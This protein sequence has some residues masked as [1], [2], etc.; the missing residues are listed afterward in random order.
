MSG[1]RSAA[2]DAADP[3]RDGA[4]PAAAVRGGAGHGRVPR[5]DPGEERLSAQLA[6]RRSGDGRPA[7]VHH[8]LRMERLRSELADP[9]H[10]AD[11]DRGPRG[12]AGRIQPAPAPGGDRP[13]FSGCG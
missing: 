4:L 2:V 3:V 7:V 1:S 8:A 12:R 10:A 11:D 5:G 9:D 13:H 6:G